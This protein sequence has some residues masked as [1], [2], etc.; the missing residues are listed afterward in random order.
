[1]EGAKYAWEGLKSVDY[2]KLWAD[3]KEIGSTIIK[4]NTKSSEDP[5]AG[6]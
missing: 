1:V 5:N 4:V 2:G 3:T 6:K